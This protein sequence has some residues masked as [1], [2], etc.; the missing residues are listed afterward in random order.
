MVYNGGPFSTPAMSVHSC[1][2]ILTLPRGQQLMAASRLNVLLRAAPAGA[3]RLFEVGCGGEQAWLGG[4]LPG[5]RYL[6]TCLFEQAPLWNKVSDEALLMH[7]LSHGIGHDSCVILYGRNML[8]AARVAHLLLY[9]GVQDVRLLD[10]GLPAWLAAGLPLE[11]GP[12]TPYPQ[13]SEFGATFPSRPD[14]LIGMEQARA[15][16][17]Q[18]DGTL[19]SIRSWAEF[20]GQTSGYSYIAA[21][22]D[23]PG[24]RWGRA[25]AD[26]DINS[27]SDFHL[28]DGRM[29]PAADIVRFWHDNGIVRGQQVAFYCG[30][31]WRAS[32]AFYYAWLM[33]WERIS[34]FDG[35]WYEWS[36]SMP[37]QPGRC[38]A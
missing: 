14:Y 38:A 20:S 30:T 26:G 25:G 35:G 10:G 1:P 2:S 3:L 13:R 27:M 11:T 21:K 7:L 15:L 37:G 23:I 24:A 19:A 18:P 34:V 5:A 4:H 6:D 28:A 36:D 29:R 12:A 16:L 22:G 9:A 31:G 8:A 32:L 17:R 33:G